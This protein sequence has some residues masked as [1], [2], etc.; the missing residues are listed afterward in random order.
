MGTLELVRASSI[1]L[2]TAGAAPVGAL[3]GASGGW[4][5]LNVAQDS[6]TSSDDADIL[7]DC[8]SGSLIFPTLDA[9]LLVA[10]FPT[11]SDS[12]IGFEFATNDLIFRLDGG[13]PLKFTQLPA[14]FTINS[15]HIF[16]EVDVLDQLGSGTAELTSDVVG[17]TPDSTSDPSVTLAVNL[18]EAG[19]LSNLDF[20]NSHW[21]LTLTNITCSSGP[22]GLGLAFKY[23]ITGTYS[24]TTY[25]FILTPPGDNPVSPGDPIKI[26]S[27]TLNPV[28]IVTIT[29]TYPGG[30]VPV[31]PENIT[32]QDPTELIFILP[33]L[34][35]DPPIITVTITSTEFSGTVDAGKLLTIFFT[36]ATGIYTLVPGKT[37]DTL[38][39]NTDPGTT[40]EVKKP[41][42]TF[43]TGFIGG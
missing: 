31:P 27:P 24:S 17:V 35:D 41:N 2:K 16:V 26:T 11:L 22:F 7:E 4:G 29:I 12:I 34:P 40:V 14:G 10:S 30:E 3:P 20:I 33:D 32:V 25:T 5:V 13:S 37:T 28:T 15:L 42:P 6:I 43:K 18:L 23:L 39:D 38:Y 1:Y 21:G 36:N 8:S 9:G 19:P